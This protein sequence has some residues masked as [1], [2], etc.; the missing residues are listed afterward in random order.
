MHRSN[1]GGDNWEVMEEGLPIAELSDGHHCCFGFA[2]ATDL[3]SGNS[4]VVPLD[5]DNFRFPRDGQL[6]VYR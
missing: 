2:S 3:A 4:F 1:D 6:A 5:G